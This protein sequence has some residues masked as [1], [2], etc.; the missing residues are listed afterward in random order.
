[1]EYYVIRL[2]GA[3]YIERYIENIHKHMYIRTVSFNVG[4]G[5]N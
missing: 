5:G 2:H 1:M 4:Y 3:K